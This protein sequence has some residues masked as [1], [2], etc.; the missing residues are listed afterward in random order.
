MEVRTIELLAPAKNLTCGMAAI[1]HGADA[2]YIGADR[3][4]ARVAAGNSVD[5]IAE[6]CR[7]AHQFD[8]K[9]YVT[10]NTIVYDDELD[11]TLRLIDQLK[12]IGVDA[13]LV[14]DMGVYSRCLNKTPPVNHVP[15][16]STFSFHASTQTDNRMIEKVRWLSSLGFSRVVLARELSLQDIRAIHDAVPE[17]ELEVFVHGALCV[18]YSGQCYASQYCFGRSANRGACAQFCR[19][20]FALEDADGV[21]ID[22]PRHWLSLRDM[23]RIDHLEELLD[24][25]AV[26]LKIEGRLKDADYVKNVTAA[27]SQRLNDIIR[28][29]NG[30][31]KRASHGNVTYSF[32]PDLRKTFNRGFT[33]YF[34]HGR[35]SDVFSPDTPKALGEY[36]GK[37]KEIRGNSF[38]VAG[39][40]SF[41]NG[42]GLCF[43]SDDRGVRSEERGVRKDSR[44]A[45]N[46]G[47]EER[48]EGFRV[49]RVEGNRLFPLKMPSSL[50]KGMA[51]YRNNDVEFE[52]L[53]KGQTAVR[54]IAVRMVLSEVEEGFLLQMLDA[55][56][57]QLLGE[58]V[59]P[60]DKQ[61]AQKPQQEN[62]V[63][64]LSK[65]GTTP[66]ECCE[67]VFHPQQFSFFIPSS[68]LAELRRSVVEKV[69]SRCE[70]RGTRYENTADAEYRSQNNTPLT[71]PQNISR[72][73]YL[74]PRTSTQNAPRTSKYPYLYNAANQAARD[75]YRSQGIADATSLE[76]HPVGHPML[77]QCRHCLRYSLGYC[78]KQGRGE[79]PWR[80][81]LY[82]RLPDGRRFRLEFDCKN[83]QMNVYG[84]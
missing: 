4:G 12:A 29:S 24:A 46:D 79:L 82:L 31:Y 56:D 80:E 39:T 54:K 48:L 78:R 47:W 22:R 20:Y 55:A 81:P 64:Q 49:N 65:L 42:D 21:T 3:F 9:V 15:A 76:T 41:A 37:V 34:L 72:T 28:R 30:R 13:I 26:S 38:T 58:A 51:L 17:V 6:L 83:C 27:Y 1:D 33:D 59:L 53:M 35:T 67:V 18:S 50:R 2:V 71:S 68:Q 52:R 77:M 25:G 60:S 63:R 16:N 7:Y 62:I 84:E 74:A 10:V 43:F 75:F 23:C 44:G 36:V 57:G 5:D 61:Q 8:A 73:S 32:S 11:D 19:L 70:V 69:S 45:R 40:A 66:Y 14:Q